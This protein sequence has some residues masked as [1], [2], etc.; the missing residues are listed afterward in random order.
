MLVQFPAPTWQLTTVTPSVAPVSQ[1]LGSA[2][3]GA[4]GASA[5]V[6]AQ[7]S[8]LAWGGVGGT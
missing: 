1:A 8:L 6:A 4:P 5:T 7:A 3:S 2:D